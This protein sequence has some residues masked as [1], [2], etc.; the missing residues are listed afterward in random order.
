MGGRFTETVNL[1]FGL[2]QQ[3]VSAIMEYAYIAEVIQG[4]EFR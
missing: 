1:V 4:V 3:T 2:F